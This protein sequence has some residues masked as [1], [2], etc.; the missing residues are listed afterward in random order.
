MRTIKAVFKFILTILTPLILIVLPLASIVIGC[1]LFLLPGVII[2]SI[3]FE[4]IPKW[5]IV[6]FGVIPASV[7]MFLGLTG[8]SEFL[9]NFNWFK[10][11]GKHIDKSSFDDYMNK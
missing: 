3:V 9:D 10:K 4:E 11:V 8:F 2:G 1:A 7:G 5:Y 6:I